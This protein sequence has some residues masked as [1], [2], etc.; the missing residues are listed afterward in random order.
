MRKLNNKQRS[1]AVESAGRKLPAI[2]NEMKQWGYSKCLERWGANFKGRSYC[3]ECGGKWKED[4]LSTK[5]PSCDSKLKAVQHPDCRT[6]KD[7]A[8][9]VVMTT[10][11][12]Y[13]VVRM[14]WLQKG[15]E[16]GHR[17]AYMADEVM[18]HWIDGEGRIITREKRV[19]GFSY[20]A[21]QWVHWSALSVRGGDKRPGSKKAA[22][23]NICGYRT[24]PKRRL[25]SEVKRR[26]Y[27]AALEQI[28][29]HKSISLLLTSS[30]A[31]TL[32]KADQTQLFQYAMDK[33]G[34]NT[35]EE[36]WNS[37]KICIRNHY[38]VKECR[39]YF[40]YLQL[41][42]QYDKDLHN[43][44]YVCPSDLKAAHDYWM[45][46]KKRDEKKKE[47]AQRA[48]E[49][50]AETKKYRKRMAKYLSFQTEVMG[51]QIKPL[52]SVE[53]FWRHGEEMNHCIFTNEY[54]KRKTLLLEARKVE[55]G[56]AV[57]TLEYSLRMKRVVQ[58]YGR[59]NEIT[60]HHDL[61][62]N[63]LNNTKL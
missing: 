10:W 23:M 1:E 8:Y 43:S 59:F 14:V 19:N 41:L 40:D 39:M 5:C 26:G 6:H 49:M 31:E 46:R 58:A 21:D 55:D 56:S 29:A 7:S 51:I 61:I 53:D 12:G 57:E 30:R 54:W 17:A 35:I 27:I 45:E 37:I 38:R 4:A 33:D 28:G 15:M 13:Q 48:K 25:L 22:R 36:Y 60:E 44:H 24:Y 52:Q 32:I 50:A 2:T 3:F 11:K 42:Q 62:I 16:R 47:M 18:Q 20:Y 9:M 34:M 63:H